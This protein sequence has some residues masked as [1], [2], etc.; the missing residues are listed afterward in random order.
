MYLY[1]YKYLLLFYDLVIT[2]FAC[3]STCSSNVI[4]TCKTR[5]ID[6]N[7]HVCM[8]RGAPNVLR[9]V[10]LG[11]VL[12]V[13]WWLLRLLLHLAQWLQ[14]LHEKNRGAGQLLLPIPYMCITVVSCNSQLTTAST[15]NRIKKERKE[16]TQKP[17][18][19]SLFMLH[20]WLKYM[21][22]TVFSPRHFS[23]VPVTA[24]VAPVAVAARQ[25]R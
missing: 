10:Y 22:V 7:K 23:G 19:L 20:A 16:T 14:N 15:Y 12:M 2:N 4:Y 18:S 13:H 21:Q 3:I 5:L 17:L 6:M 11:F 25:K 8:P 1:L 9:S 24:W